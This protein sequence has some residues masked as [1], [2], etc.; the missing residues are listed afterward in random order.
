MSSTVLSVRDLNV[1]FPLPRRGTVHAVDGVSLDIAQGD[2]LGLVGESGCGKTS[3]GRTILRLQKPTSGQV[4]YRGWPLTDDMLPFRRH[5]QMIFQ[6]PYASLNPRMSLRTIVAEP[7]HTLRLHGNGDIG[8]R[9]QRL[10]SLVG[11]SSDLAHRYPH[12]LSGGQ[13]Q[14]IGIARALAADPD[15]IVA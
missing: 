3:L 7:I 13:R 4:F 10:L 5:M 9:V 8:A 6:D 1:H 15:F 12:E 11:L 14:R 2:T